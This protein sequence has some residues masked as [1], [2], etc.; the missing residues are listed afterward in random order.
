M[1]GTAQ[2]AAMSTGLA[3]VDM[4]FEA[5]VILV[6]DVDRAKALYENLGWRLDADFRFDNGFRV[7][8]F[9]P[10]GSGCSIQFGANITPGAPGSA[11]G[12]YLIVSNI[13]PAR[14]ELV[15]GG[16]A[17]SEVFHPE[18]PGAHFSPTAPAVASADPRPI[19][20]P[21]APSPLSVIRTASGGCCRRS[22]PGFPGAS[23]L[24]RPRSAPQ[25]IWRT[26]SVV[27]RLPMASTRSAPGNATRTGPTVTPRTWWRSR[28]GL[29]CRRKHFAAWKHPKLLYRWSCLHML[30]R[31][32]VLE[33]D[34]VNQTP[35]R[36]QAPVSSLQSRGA[37]TPSGRPQ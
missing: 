12:L 27:L 1:S 13:E 36:A 18:T 4:K 3:R 35:Y 23:T 19:T 31:F 20:P 28:L 21:T 7:V 11:H 9:T 24:P 26:L 6:S 16:V 37:C 15:T 30:P 5:V 10:P 8:Q 25:A 32:F 2:K 33:A 14:G 17:V 22:R 29:S 34:L